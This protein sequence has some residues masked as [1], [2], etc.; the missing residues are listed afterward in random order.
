MLLD[1][2][3]EWIA[4][5]IESVVQNRLML[6]KDRQFDIILLSNIADYSSAHDPQG[7]YLT[8]F[9]KKIIDPLSQRLKPKGILALAYL[10]KTDFTSSRL[11]SGLYRSAIDNPLER[12]RVFKAS[13]SDTYKEMTFKSAIRGKDSLFCLI[14]N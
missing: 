8:E 1:K 9:K 13:T 7:D 11:H 3:M 12:K 10:Y 2:K 5:P 4:H 14:K 6:L